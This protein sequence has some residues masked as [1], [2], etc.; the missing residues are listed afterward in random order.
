MIPQYK[1]CGWVVLS[2]VGWY[3]WQKWQVLFWMIGF[4]STFGYNL[5]LNYIYIQAIQRY[6]WFTPF[7]AHRCTHPQGFS[8]S[9]SRLLATDLNTETITSYH[10]LN[11]HR[12]T[13]C[14]LVY[15]AIISLTVTSLY[16]TQLSPS[17]SELPK[18]KSESRYIAFARTTHR[19]PSSVVG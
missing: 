11:P 7:T 15:A 19:K 2:C 9:T 13:S 3:T 6:H 10:T 17:A 16:F 12:P 14:T 1:G 8:V 18:S 5:S 4:I